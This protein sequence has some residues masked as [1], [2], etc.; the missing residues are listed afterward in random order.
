MIPFLPDV[1]QTLF[2][3]ENIR[4][5]HMTSSPCQQGVGN[6]I[7]LKKVDGCESNLLPGTDNNPVT[8]SFKNEF[9]FDLDFRRY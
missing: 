2:W 8:K 9:K 5:F 1:L 7:N 3:E 4:K 6:K